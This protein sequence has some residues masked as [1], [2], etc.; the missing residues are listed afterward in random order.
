MAKLQLNRI[1]GKKGSKKEVEWSPDDIKAFE[2]LRASLA[3]HLELFRVDP[4]RPFILRADA[5]DKAVGAVLEQEREVTTGETK[6]VPV[7]F[8]SRKLGKHQ[9]NWTPREK[10]T[11]AVV[12]ALKKWEGWIGLQPV[13]VTTDHRSLENL[14]KEKMDTPS[15]PAGRRARWH[16][17]LSKFD[18]TVQYIPGKDNVVADALSRYAY[19]ACQAF[20][21]T[22]FHG[23]E[24]ARK[25]MKDIIARERAEERDVA[26]VCGDQ[27]G[28]SVQGKTRRVLLISDWGEA[29][30]ARPV[31]TRSGRNTGTRE[32]DTE[33]EGHPEGTPAPVSQL[34]PAAEPYH[35]L[36]K[37]MADPED[38][39]TETEGETESEAEEDEEVDIFGNLIR[40]KPLAAQ[41]GPRAQSPCLTGPATE[42]ALPSSP[43]VANPSPCVNLVQ[44]TAAD[45]AQPPSPADPWDTAYRASPWWADWWMAAHSGQPEW[46]EY[47]HLDGPYMLWKGRVCL[48]ESMVAS[49]IADFHKFMGHPG[50]RRL[51]KELQRRYAFPATTR[52]EG[53]VAK[54][55]RECMVCQASEHANK[56]LKEPIAQTFIPPY[57]MNSVALDLFTLPKVRWQGRPF[58]TVILCVDR[59]TGWI[60]VAPTTGQGL[61]AEKA[62]H[63]MMETGW[64]IFGVPAIIT[65][66]QGPQFVGQWWRTMCG[67]LGI[68]QACSQA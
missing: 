33:V 18:I 27:K 36:T 32:A 68:R 51:A 6:A 29:L 1:D 61:T 57:L 31:T 45:G 52:V 8:F 9:I 56:S 11:Y 28:K 7:G 43:P 62:A 59:L 41:M 47:I 14:V 19:P 37:E 66:D 55:R 20:Q 50:I 13:L 40:P 12:S 17:Q 10:E 24:A 49:T 42:L 2:Q 39:M 48:P 38:P 34:N 21:D 64:D 15:G 3:D 35:P 25:E 60:I 5:S 58:D 63:L 23:S 22:S 16:E 44:Q 53:E 26:L 65:S 67:R 4:D 46:P 30:Q 54:I